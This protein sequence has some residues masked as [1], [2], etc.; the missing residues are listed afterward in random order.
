MK[1]SRIQHAALL[2]I[3]LF[4]SG[5]LFAQSSKNVSVNKFN[6]VSISSGI[7]L[8]LTQGPAEGLKF[9]GDKEMLESVIV[10]KDG[11][12]IKIR[13]KNGFHW[14]GLFSK[15]TLKAYVTYK[16]LHAVSASGGSDVFTQ[17][18][19]RTDRLTLQASGGSDL[20]M[21]IACKDIEIHSSGGSD[22]DLKGNAGNMVLHTSGGSDVNAFNFRVDYA[23]VEASGGSDANVYVTKALEASA[24]GGSDVHYKGNASYKKTSFSKSGSVTKVD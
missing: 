23:R 14:S 18:T 22:V 12:G 10:E 2:L 6:E 3:V 24:S 8:Y 13:F 1:R 20:K 9:V 16:T 7:D 19:L 17:N 4:S 11:S 15:Q 5:S 21:D